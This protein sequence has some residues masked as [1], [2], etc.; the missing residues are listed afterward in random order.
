MTLRLKTEKNSTKQKKK[1]TDTGREKEKKTKAPAWAVKTKG[2]KGERFCVTG[3]NTWSEGKHTE[4][5]K[6]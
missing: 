1:E 4:V 2:E 3:L 5:K 6:Y